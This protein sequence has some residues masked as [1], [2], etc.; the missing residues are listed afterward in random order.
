MRPAWVLA[1]AVSAALLFSAIPAHSAAPLS[2]DLTPTADGPVPSALFDQAATAGTVRVN[3]VTDLRTDLAAA[4]DAGSTVVSY[5]TLPMV[6]L[7]VDTAGLQELN[8]QPG[9]VSV[10]EDVPV[11]PSLNESTVKI[12]S[13]RTAAAGKTGAGTAIAIL[14][15]GV[16]THHPFFG[17]RVTTEACF[18]VNDE[19]YGATS[20]CPNG[21]G[22]QEGTGSADADAGLCATL[23]SACSHGTHV[24]GIAAGDG[25]GITGAPARGVAPGADIIA[26]QVFSYI[27]SEAYCGAGRSPCV[28]SFTSSQ[29]KALEKVQSLKQAGVDVVAANMSLGGRPVATACTGDPRLPVIDSLLAAGVATVAAAGND[30]NTGAVSAPGCVP[31]AIAVGSTT[32]DDQLSSFSNRGPLLDLLAPGTGI[33]SSVPGGTYV[34]KNGTSMAAPHVAGAFAVLRQTFPTKTIAELEALLKT[35]GAP[36]AYTGA[37]T[38]RID[39]NAAVGGGTGTPKPEDPPAGKPLAHRFDNDVPVAIPD[40]PGTNVPGTPAHSPIVVTGHPEGA[41]SDLFVKVAYAH[42]WIGDVRLELVSPTGKTYLLKSANLN[43]GGTTY[44]GTFT[45]DATG[46]PSDGEWR[47]RATDIDDG[48]TG[49]LNTW[50]LTFP[51]PFKSST[52]KTIPDTGSVTSDI[53]VSGITGNASG[54]L[55]V[56]ADLTHGKIGD[57]SLTLTSPDSRTFTLKPYGSEAGGTLKT[58]YGIDATAATASGTWTLKVTDATGGSTGQLNGWSLTFP[59]YENQT[60]KQI[61]DVNYEEIWTRT[62]AL[63]GNGSARTQVYAHIEHANL[64]NLK[65]DLVTPNGTLLP[66]KGSGSPQGPGVIKKTYLV[67]TSAHPANGT[68]KLRVDDVMSG[69]TGTIH[70]FVLRF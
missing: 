52:V 43:T 36:I 63:T 64:A 70:T 6:T 15:T 60:V 20:L 42:A 7:K 39:V 4:S 37:T 2:D 45:V 11:P 50:S 14:D 48:S 8:A 32:D 24:A 53:A 26:L 30:G 67:D 66:L 47:V 41:P 19:A 27:D 56:Y 58:T 44:S 29:I 18:S 40:S 38:P 49:S 55:Q 21:T 3:V 62:A 1:A 51:T 5:D 10:A 69:N 23:G 54:P 57:L 22:F 25:T 61:P 59:S 33:V 12:G 28:L 34:G 65:I 46:Q 17:G 68:W 13:D 16:A 35:T 9:V 31:S